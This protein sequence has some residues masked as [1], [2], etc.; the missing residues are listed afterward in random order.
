MAELHASNGVLQWHYA[1]R[2]IKRPFKSFQLYLKLWYSTSMMIMIIWCFTI[3]Q[4]VVSVSLIARGSDDFCLMLLEVSFPGLGLERQHMLPWGIGGLE[5]A[6]RISPS[7]RPTETPAVDHGVFIWGRHV[8]FMTPSPRVFSP[9]LLRCYMPSE[10][11]W[12]Q[13]RIASVGGS[14][15]TEIQVEIPGTYE[16]MGGMCCRE[17]KAKARTAMNCHN[18]QS[19]S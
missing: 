5:E 7:C 1:Q 4:V 2:Y 11:K 10:S 19:N 14:R 16:H 6:I 12:R 18:L 9:Q 15:S 13:V 8:P 3:T 17:N